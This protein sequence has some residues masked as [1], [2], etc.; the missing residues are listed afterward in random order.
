MAKIISGI[1]NTITEPDWK[2][3]KVSKYSTKN[4]NFQ[5]ILHEKHK[6]SYYFF[7]ATFSSISAISWQPVLVV[8]ETEYPEKTTDHWQATGKNGIIISNKD[9]LYKFNIGRS[10]L[11]YHILVINNYIHESSAPFL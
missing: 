4:T 6:L 5:Q 3:R 1:E 9:V 10:Y 2:I 7:N 8:E 11:Y